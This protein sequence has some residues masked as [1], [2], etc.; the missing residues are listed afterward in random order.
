MEGQGTVVRITADEFI[1]VNDSPM[2]ESYRLTA[3]SFLVKGFEAELHDWKYGIDS[4]R[5]VKITRDSLVMKQGNEY[6]RLSR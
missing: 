5:I 6:M 3:D 1:V 4:F 2:P